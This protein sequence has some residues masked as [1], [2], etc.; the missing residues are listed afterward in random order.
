MVRSLFQTPK[1]V[2]QCYTKYLKIFGGVYWGRNKDEQ[3][4]LFVSALERSVAL[5]NRNVWRSICVHCSHKMEHKLT[6]LI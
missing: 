6:T 1:G 5:A 3:T 4:S 2:D